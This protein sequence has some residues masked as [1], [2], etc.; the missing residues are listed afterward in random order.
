M[1]KVLPLIITIIM[2]GMTGCAK[3]VESSTFD[4]NTENKYAFAAAA[5]ATGEVTEPTPEPTII[6]STEPTATPEPTPTPTATPKPVTETTTAPEPT[7]TATPVNTPSKVEDTL[8]RLLKLSVP[9]EDK[10]KVTFE[11]SQGPAPVSLI[12]KIEGLSYEKDKLP[13]VTGIVA[14]DGKFNST[15]DYF[16]GYQY[17]NG[18]PTDLFKGTLGI[19]AW[20]GMPTTAECYVFIKCKDDGKTYYYKHIYNITSVNVK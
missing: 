16:Y 15:N 12:Y 9:G 11:S 3:K 19:G 8:Q 5:D 7:L 18:K 14:F 6:P 10:Y 20:K 13:N 17:D 4:K 1:R 2:I